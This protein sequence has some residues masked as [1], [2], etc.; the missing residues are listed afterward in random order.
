MRFGFLITLML[1]M[2]AA[3]IPVAAQPEPL[4]VPVPA[5]W[6]AVDEEYRY[7]RDNLWE[8][9]NGAAELFLTYGFREL[10]VLD[11]EKGDSALTVS[12]YDMSRPLDAF[13]IYESEKPASGSELT[14]VG[15]AAILQPPYRGLVLKDRFYVKIEVGGDDISA[16]VLS[17]A[18][19]DVAAALPGNDELP[20]Q[21]KALPEPGRVPGT[22]SFSGRN[23][24][25]FGDLS[26]CLHAAYKL[27]DGTE[28]SLF[29]MK[30]SQ[31]FIAGKDRRWTT[32]ETD[33]DSLILWREVPYEGVVVL[34]GD[35]TALL[36]ISGVPD[37]EAAT[38]VL[39]SLA[40]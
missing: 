10:A 32:V 35:E 18:M 30:P 33:D 1:L 26:N 7:G 23:Y 19:R 9:V 17:Q 16:E 40:N 6:T 38:E 5:G 22:V 34:R 2:L 31:S 14:G 11:V 24:L 28:F 25:G 36:G 27:D 12:I 39:D 29:V 3:T 20:A 37:F 15:A 8:Y 13:G 21:L 4:P